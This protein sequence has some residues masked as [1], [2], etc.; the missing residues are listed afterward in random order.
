MSRSARE[1]MTTLA[2]AVAAG[3]WSLQESLHGVAR[4][5]LAAAASACVALTLH[6]LIKLAREPTAK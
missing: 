1:W 3:L 2:G 5:A 4:V 6:S